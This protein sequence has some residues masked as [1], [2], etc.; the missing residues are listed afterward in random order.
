MSDRQTA[1]R[2]VANSDNTTAQDDLLNVKETIHALLVQY[3]GLQGNR[4]QIFGLTEPDQGGTYALIFVDKLRLDEAAFT[5][6]ADVAVVPLSNDLMPFLE[7]GL[8]ALSTN[9]SGRVV[10]IVT[11]GSE[12]TAWK[13]LLPACVERCR[14]WSHRANCE[15]VAQGKIP[16]SVVMDEMPLCSCGRGVGLPPDLRKLAAIKLLLPFA[17]RAAISPLFSVSYIERVAGALNKMKPAAKRPSPNAPAPRNAPE[18]EAGCLHCGQP[19]KPRLLSCSKCKTAK[20]CS[21]S[22]QRNDWKGHKVTCK[23]G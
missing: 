22:C 14:T 12:V 6:V 3:A 19:G 10:S 8:R 1:M 13:R 17:T 21:P 2:E 7:P 4:S 18:V 9:S 23:T 16:L 20:Y 5:V 15:Y 11:R